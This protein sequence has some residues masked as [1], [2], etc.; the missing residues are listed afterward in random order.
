MPP[1]P[2][3]HSLLTT[4]KVGPTSTFSLPPSTVVL[5]R[6]ELSSCTSG[7]GDFTRPNDGD[8]DDDDDRPKVDSYRFWDMPDQPP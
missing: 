8:N 2:T 5:T 4:Q 6:K 3:A 7:T 1:P